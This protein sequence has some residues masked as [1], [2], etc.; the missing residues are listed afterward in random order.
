[1]CRNHGHKACQT[2]KAEQ[3]FWTAL[4][5]SARAHNSGQGSTIT[6]VTRGSFSY[7]GMTRTGSRV[8]LSR[9]GACPCDVHR[10]IH[11]A[12]LT[13]LPGKVLETLAKGKKTAACTVCCYHKG[14]HK[15]AGWRQRQGFC[16]VRNRSRPAIMPPSRFCRPV[17]APCMRLPPAPYLRG[18]TCHATPE[19]AITR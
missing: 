7:D 5:K 17:F 19:A 14:C 18:E 15:T 8:S 2:R 10:T 4:E 3:K 12:P 1:M 9:G 11:P 13:M 16:F 6:R